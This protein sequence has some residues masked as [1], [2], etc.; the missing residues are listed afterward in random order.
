LNVRDNLVLHGPSVRDRN[1]R[2]GDPLD[3]AQIVEGLVG[4]AGDDLARDAERTV[5]LVAGR[6]LGRAEQETDR[7]S[8]WGLQRVSARKLTCGF[9]FPRRMGKGTCPICADP[10]EIVTRRTVHE[11]G[12]AV[13]RT[14]YRRS[15]CS[16]LWTESTTT[17]L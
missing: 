15:H 7:R 9:G 6:P 8:V 17:D 13:K 5:V 16:L 1:V 2:E 4:D 12:S 3:G 10:S 14:Q 11:N